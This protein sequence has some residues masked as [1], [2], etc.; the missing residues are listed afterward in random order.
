M[1]IFQNFSLLNFNTL[2]IDASARFFIFINNYDDL[3]AIFSD[4]K[5][6]KFDKFFLGAGSNILFTKNFDGIVLK[7]NLKDITI[8]D[9]NID[10]IILECDS[11]LLWDDFVRFCVNNNLSGVENLAY[12][13]G[14]IG[15]APVQNIGAYGV[16]QSSSFISLD[17]FSFDNSKELKFNN[18]DCNFNYRY[19]I[20]KNDKFKNIFIKKVRYKLNKN[21]KA[22]INYN[23]LKK[24]F[25]KSDAGKLK[26]V[27]VYNAVCEIRQNKLPEPSKIPNAGSFF[28]NPI[29]TIEEFDKISHHFQGS[30]Y[31]KLNE[32]QIKISAA[33]LIE[34]AGFKGYCK[35]D[36]CVYDKHS[37]IICNKGNAKGEEIV[38]FANEIIETIKEKFYITLEPEVIY[39]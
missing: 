31:Y 22:N 32:R 26:L 35:G 5:L 3:N 1:Q 25:E 9:E 36:V 17:A 33:Y 7:N 27:D 28:K 8:I 11:G 30:G 29:I 37:L 20:F 4:K 12:I 14:T 24:Y 21:F 39:I 2:K 10:E 6:N 18:N 23:D 34:K 15:A 16:E 19:S 13:P 38:N